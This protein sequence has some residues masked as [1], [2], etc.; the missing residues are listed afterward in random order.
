[1]GNSVHISSQECLRAA[2]EREHDMALRALERR[3]VSCLLDSG[4]CLA[5]CVVTG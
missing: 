2:P 3:L 5:S 1:M 4:P